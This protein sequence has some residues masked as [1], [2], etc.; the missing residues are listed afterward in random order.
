MT[1]TTPKYNMTKDNNPSEDDSFETRE[2]K[3]FLYFKTTFNRYNIQKI[4]T[5][6]SSDRE[7]LTLFDTYF[8]HG[9]N[10]FNDTYKIIKNIE[11]YAECEKEFSSLAYPITRSFAPTILKIYCVENLNEKQN[12]KYFIIFGMKR[13]DYTGQ[14]SD[15]LFYVSQK[16]QSRTKAKPSKTVFDAGKRRHLVK[17]HVFFKSQKEESVKNL[18][19]M[20][21]LKIFLNIYVNLLD[22]RFSVD[23]FNHHCCTRFETSKT[24]EKIF[25]QKLPPAFLDLNNSVRHIKLKASES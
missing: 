11:R 19:A 4:A 1:Q 24:N 23:D 5:P 9:P 20:I 25:F 8:A 21:Y 15:K 3:I 17:K 12:Y 16:L 13:C 6:E 2:D 14:I 7:F 22:I 18:F 10:T